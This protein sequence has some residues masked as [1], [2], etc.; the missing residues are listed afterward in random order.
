MRVDNDHPERVIVWLGDLGRDLNTPERL[1][2]QH[3]N[4]I[5]EGG[6]SRTSYKRNILGLFVD[7]RDAGLRTQALVPAGE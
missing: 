1:H 2:W 5:P 4:I 7:S 3:Y 6:I